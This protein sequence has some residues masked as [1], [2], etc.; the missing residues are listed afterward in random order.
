[1]N[2]IQ[3]TKDNYFSVEAEKEYMGSTQFKS[4]VSAFGGCEAQAMAKLNRTKEWLEYSEKKE[5]N[6]NFLIGQYLHAWNEGEKAMCKFRE[7]HPEMYTKQGTLYAKFKYIHDVINVIEK[8]KLFMKA[9][10]GKKEQIFTAELFGMKWKIAIDSIQ[11]DIE[12]FTDLKGMQD[13][14]KK[15]WDNNKREYVNFIQAYRYDIQMAIYAEIHRLSQKNENHYT[16][17]IA[18]VEKKQIPDK[19]VFVFH[20]EEYSVADF[21]R[22]TLAEIE[23]YAERVRQVK[24][25]GVEPERCEEC[26][27]CKFTKK[28]KDVKFWKDINIK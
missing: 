22:D 11:D 4:F 26:D 8:D 3:L 23:P 5:E 1:M 19:E 16:P 9:L 17:H 13:I 25:E 28:L 21:V 27:Y 15:H 10:D 20:N 2:T 12:I 14:N 18:A 7:S 6:E 24:Y